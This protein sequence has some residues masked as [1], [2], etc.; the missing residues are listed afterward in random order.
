VVILRQARVP[1]FGQRLLWYLKPQ[2]LL[3]DRELP[4]RELAWRGEA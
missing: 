1:L 4:L 3:I 2:P